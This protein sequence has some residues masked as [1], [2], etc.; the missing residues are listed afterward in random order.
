[1]LNKHLMEKAE[2]YLLLASLAHKFY[3]KI[4]RLEQQPVYFQLLSDLL[5]TL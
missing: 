4:I 1:M 5:Q 2:L 3:S